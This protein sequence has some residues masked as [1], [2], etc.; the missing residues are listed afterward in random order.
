[1]RIVTRKLYRAF[2][3]LDAFTDEQCAD[4]LANVKQRRARF[5][6]LIIGLPATLGVAYL[7]GF[8][9]FVGRVVMRWL[10][11]M[12]LFKMNAAGDM[13]IMIVFGT[14][15]TLWVAGAALIPLTL[16][17]RLLK[18]AL[19]QVINDQLE[20][21]RCRQCSYSLI[22]QQPTGERLECPECG[23]KTTL[24]EL[25]ITLEDLIPPAP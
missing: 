22:G 12:G 2:P 1:M 25:G 5:S 7:I 6:M 16:R 23:R 14:F 17:D 10:N 21:T 8:P 9:L 3:E 13:Q 11:D 20:K 24:K 15:I 19:Y 4:Y 18:K